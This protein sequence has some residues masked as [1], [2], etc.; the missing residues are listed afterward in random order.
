MRILSG[1]EKLKKCNA[2][3]CKEQKAD[4]SKLIGRFNKMSSHFNIYFYSQFLFFK[5][6]HNLFGSSILHE[7]F[8]GCHIY[9]NCVIMALFCSY[10]TI[11]TQSLFL[12]Y[13]LLYAYFSIVGGFNELLANLNH[14]ILCSHVCS[15]FFEST[16]LQL[17]LER[18]TWY[19]SLLTNN[20]SA[21][22][23]PS[24]QVIIAVCWCA[25]VVQSYSLQRKNLGCL[26]VFVRVLCV[27]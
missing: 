23:L 6:F 4:A 18:P 22:A 24:Q 5:C 21:A 8:Y 1:F 17:N 2:Q 16:G 14:F 19:I 10:G 27:V 25:S 26:W 9:T 11:Q 12:Y 20:G 3:G 13:G 15:C 7:T